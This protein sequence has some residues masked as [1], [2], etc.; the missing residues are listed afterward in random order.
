MAGREGSSDQVFSKDE[1]GHKSIGVS[2]S[3][4]VDGKGGVVAWRGG[5]RQC[6]N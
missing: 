5:G 4:V 1:A 6:A 2:V 3:I